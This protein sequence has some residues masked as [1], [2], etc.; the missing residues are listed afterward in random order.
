LW[1]AET[2]NRRELFFGAIPTENFTAADRVI[3]QIN[4]KER[5]CDNNSAIWPYP[6]KTSIWKVG[7]CWYSILPGVAVDPLAAGFYAVCSKNC[8]LAGWGKQWAKSLQP[9]APGQYA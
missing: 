5:D 4:F 2:G 8:W 9:F 1:I 6:V 7:Y 3:G